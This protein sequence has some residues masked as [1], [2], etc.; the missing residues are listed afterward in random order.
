MLISIQN[1]L[2]IIFSSICHLII[3]SDQDRTLR[4]AAVCLAGLFPSKYDQIWNRDISWQTIPIHTVPRHEDYILYPGKKC[5]KEDRAFNE[6][7]QS[8]EFI[9]ITDKYKNLLSQLE[10][11]SGKTLKSFHDVKDLYDTL[12]IKEHQNFT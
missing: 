1:L 5:P 11:Q 10:M 9:A 6:Y 4:S 2:N 8:P 12:W 7:L 3:G